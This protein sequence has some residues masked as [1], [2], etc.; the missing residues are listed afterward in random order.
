MQEQEVSN[1]FFTLPDRRPPKSRDKGEIDDILSR[2]IYLPYTHTADI[3]GAKIQLITNSRHVNEWWQLNWYLS[4]DDPDGVVYVIKGVE[5]YEPRLF[6]DLKRRLVV[7]TNSEY[8]GAAKSAGALGLAG[9]VL[10]EKG[11]YPIHGACVGIP[12]GVI[13][14]APTGTGKTSQMHEILW[15]IRNSKVVGDDY[16]FVEFD[17]KNGNPI[18]KATEDQLYMRPDI[19]QEHPT[20]IPLFNKLPLENVVTKKSNCA[21]K[22][23][24]KKKMEP[25]YR[26]VVSG[27]T[28]CVFDKG[29]KCCYWSYGNSRVMFPRHMFP[30][31]SKNSHGNPVVIEKGRNNVVDEVQ[32]KY[33]FLLTRDEES[34]PLRRLECDEIIATLREG[35]YII[36]PGAGPPEKWGEPGFEPFYNPYPPELDLDIQER[37]FRRLYE[38][39]VLFYLGNTGSHDGR[40]ITV[41]QTHTYIRAILEV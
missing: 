18:A 40:K 5:G 6:Y 22:T 38:S 21:Q 11:Q 39:G 3:C 27:E 29:E 2:R 13:I 26:S 12:D 25:C 32:L 28:T 10:K 36:R 4:D 30:M 14:M 31:L 7:I 33:I 34:P 16:I 19:A 17:K 37:F 8:Y 15:N 41:H 1:N 23:E 24:N 9:E 20:F 35:K